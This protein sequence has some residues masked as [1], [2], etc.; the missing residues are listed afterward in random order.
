MKI[1]CPKLLG[2]SSSPWKIK[3]KNRKREID[4][5]PQRRFL[6]LLCTRPRGH[7]ASRAA[8][9]VGGGE[10]LARG[11]HGERGDRWHAIWTRTLEHRGEKGERCVTGD[12][13]V[14]SV[15]NGWERS[16]SPPLATRRHLV[17]SC[18]ASSASASIRRVVEQ[19]TFRSVERVE[20]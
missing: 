12:K 3:E 16:P 18:V 4:A 14:E 7:G 10:V 20:C 9:L 15:D 8:G 5:K 17:A 11:A 6:F 19:A 2:S 1:S 13:A